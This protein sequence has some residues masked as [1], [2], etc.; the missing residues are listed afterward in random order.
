MFK[1]AVTSV[2]FRSNTAYEI[3]KAAKESRLDAIEWG[4]DVHAPCNNPSVLKEINKMCREEGILI[5]SYGSY[6]RIGKDRPEDIEPYLEAANLLGTDCIRVWCGE[7]GSAEIGSDGLSALADQGRKTAEIAEKAGI[8]LCLECHPFT[9][10]D[11]YEVSRRYISEV[12]SPFLRMYWQPNQFKS[13]EYNV[14][15]ASALAEI[16]RNIHVFHWDSEYKKYPLKE[17]TEIWKKY[18]SCFGGDHTL[19]L[20]FMHDDRIESLKET[21]ATLISWLQEKQ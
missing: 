17:G 1:T 6:Y 8:Q 20:E 4:S 15:S 7:K 10:T 13:E 18:L 9:L 2:S 11:D 14:K 3:I 12:G 21:A 16:T 19:I 5:S